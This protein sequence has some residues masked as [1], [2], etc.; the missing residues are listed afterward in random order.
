MEKRFL[1][2]WFNWDKDN[3]KAAN[4]TGTTMIHVTKGDMEA[5]DIFVPPIEEQRRIVAKIDAMSAR[6]RRARADLDRVEAL[7]ARAK[8]ALLQ[9]AFADEGSSIVSLGEILDDGPTN[10]WSPKSGDDAAGALTLKLSA[11]T[12]GKMLLDERT[13]KRIY[14]TLDESSNFWLEP[15]DLLVQRA[16]SLEYVGASAIYEGPKHT[17]IYPDLMMRIRIQDPD[18]RRY[19]W[20]FLNSAL[21]RSYLKQRATGTAGNMPKISGTTLRSLPVPLPLSLGIR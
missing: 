11:T 18:L 2:H 21:A 8:Q 10:G 5:R 19:I 14:E 7:A 20:Y 12:S 17:Y 9:R 4:G 1:Y 3:I 15:G 16:N 6:S 13:T